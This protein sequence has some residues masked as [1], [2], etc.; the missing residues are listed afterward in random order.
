MQENWV[1]EGKVG[2]ISPIKKMNDIELARNHK[3]RTIIHQKLLRELGTE[4]ID[5]D[6]LLQYLDNNVNHYANIYYR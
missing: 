4:I 2:Q 1:S 6:N 5:I 3:K